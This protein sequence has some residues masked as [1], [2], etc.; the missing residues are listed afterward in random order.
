MESNSINQNQVIFYGK[1]DGS[2]VDYPTNVYD[3]DSQNHDD[4]R[5]GDGIGSRK[6]SSDL[7]NLPYWAWD[8]SD[9][10]RSYF[11]KQLIEN[12]KTISQIKYDLLYDNPFGQTLLLTCSSLSTLFMYIKQ[13]QNAYL[14]N[15]ALSIL[16]LMDSCFKEIYINTL[17][18]L[19]ITP[20]IMECFDSDISD[21]AEKAA[22]VLCK[23]AE[24]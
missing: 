8:L 12:T 24:F 19:G 22:R 2:N 11:E 6:I 9:E 4:Q 13:N 14:K 5:Q 18:D 10:M 15:E 16:S 20:I 23:L 21:I 3:Q 1:D 17:I 7:P